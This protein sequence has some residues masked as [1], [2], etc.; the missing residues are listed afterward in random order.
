MIAITNSTEYPKNFIKGKICMLK[1]IE[2]FS[3]AFQE[4]NDTREFS[5]KYKLLMISLMFLFESSNQYFFYSARQVHFLSL[6]LHLNSQYG[7]DS[8]LNLMIDLVMWDHP[9]DKLWL[10]RKHARAHKIPRYRRHIVTFRQ[11]SYRLTILNLSAVLDQ[12]LLIVIQY[13][14]VSF[15]P[16]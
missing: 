2:E 13:F 15:L 4:K 10:F 3:A 12:M 1:D 7:A 14:Y 11:H 16:L 5:L 9:A 6:S 8:D